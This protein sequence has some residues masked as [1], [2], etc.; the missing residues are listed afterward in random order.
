MKQIR[1]L[2]ST[3]NRSATRTDVGPTRSQ[4]PPDTWQ[5]FRVIATFLHLPKM[6]IIASITTIILHVF[7]LFYVASVIVNVLVANTR[8][9]VYFIAWATVS[10]LRAPFVLF[11][12]LCCTVMSDK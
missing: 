8:R 9:N 6:Y 11:R 2:V 3:D 5:A 12:I 4:P 7:V 10:A 1:R